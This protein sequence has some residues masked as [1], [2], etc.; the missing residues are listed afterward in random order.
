MH[1]KK[2]SLTTL[3]YAGRGLRVSLALSCTYWHGLTQSCGKK[4][5]SLQSL[6]LPYPVTQYVVLVGGDV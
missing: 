2:Q 6:S 4:K 5:K 3:S 1:T